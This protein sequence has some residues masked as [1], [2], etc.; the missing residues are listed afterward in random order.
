M[1]GGKK[2]VVI[3]Q[4]EY[5]RLKSDNQHQPTANPLK[6]DMKKSENVM[7][8]VQDGDLPVDEKIRVFAEE[9][10]NLKSLYHSLVKPKPIEV[11]MKRKRNDDDD[12]DDDADVGDLR[13]KVETKKEQYNVIEDAIL[14]T[15]PKGSKTDAKLLLKAR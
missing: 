1:N 6:N 10:N 8:N 4:E 12:D 2:H 5:S 14:K 7:R 9:L 3:T 15:V 13:V 11:V